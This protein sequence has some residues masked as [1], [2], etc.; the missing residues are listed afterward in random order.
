MDIVFYREQNP[1]KR[2]PTGVVEI[3]KE[4]MKVAVDMGWEMRG[5]ESPT[6]LVIELESILAKYNLTTDDI[7]DSEVKKKIK[8]IKGEKL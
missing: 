1:S 4:Q 2:F 3:T 5:K 6:A 7:G 8:I